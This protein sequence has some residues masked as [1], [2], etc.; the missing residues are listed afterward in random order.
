MGRRQIAGER[1]FKPFSSPLKKKNTHTHTPCSIALPGVGPHYY[2][3]HSHIIRATE[4]GVVDHQPAVTAVM[5]DG[6]SHPSASARHKGPRLQPRSVAGAT[7]TAPSASPPEWTDVSVANRASLG[8]AGSVFKA[9]PSQVS[10]MAKCRRARG[11]RSD[12][13]ESGSCFFRMHT[14]FP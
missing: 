11:F 6:K 8:G 7:C 1:G 9:A 14:S 5:Y 3:S 13:S 12:A 2:C 10:R 4:L